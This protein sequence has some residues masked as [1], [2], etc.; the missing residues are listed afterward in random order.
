MAMYHSLTSLASIALV[1]A[2]IG[3]GLRYGINVVVANGLGAE[4]LGLFAFGMVVM[5]MGGVIARLGLDNAALKFVPVHL[6]NDDQGSLVGTVLL[7]LGTPLVFGSV[8]TA[9]V[10]ASSDSIASVTGRQFGPTVRLFAL[11]IPFFAAMMVG[12]A[13]TRGLQET[14][15]QVYTRDLGQS[16]VA[17]ALVAFGAY[18]A[19]DV[20]AVVVGYV[21]SFVVGVGIVAVFLVREGAI[22]RVPRPRVPA[23]EVFAF[24][25]PLTLAAVIQYLITWTDVLMLSVLRR[26]TEVGWYQAAFQTSVL[27]LVVLQSVNTIFPSVASSLYERDRWPRLRDLFMGAT[28]WVTYLTVL[29][30]A[31][32]VVY[33]HQI[34]GLFGITTA[35]ASLALV[36]LCVGQTVAASTGPAGNLLVMTGHSRL[37]LYNTAVVSVIN[38]GLNYVLIQAQGIVGAAAATAFSLALLNLLRV[39]ELW[40]FYRLQPYDRTYWKGAAGVGSAVPILL[41]GANLPAPALVQIVVGGAGALA[42]FAAVLWLLGFDEVDAAVLETIS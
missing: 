21:L 7:C 12:I 26:A 35:Q 38:V 32:V 6:A 25:L 19:S 28:R 18:V 30:C 17:I 42:A 36:I 41:F 14:K 15:Y 10:I 40:Y 31:F 23:G 37:Q 11:G 20:D 5:K 8:I 16:I 24:A 1:G 13:A 9:V 3:R 27:L 22:S 29:G 34:L 2:V 39:G 33:R 4:A